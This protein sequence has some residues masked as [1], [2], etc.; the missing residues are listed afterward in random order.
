V[1]RYESFLGKRVEAR[2]RAAHIYHSASGVL[3]ADD[4]SSIFIEDDLMQGGKQ[5]MIRIE[6]PYQYILSVVELPPKPP[7]GA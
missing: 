3:A 1:K 2:Y 4:G 5:K 6:I 7:S